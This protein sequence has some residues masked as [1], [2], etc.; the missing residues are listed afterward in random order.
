VNG[1]KNFRVVFIRK[2]GEEI[3]TKMVLGFIEI[4]TKRLSTLPHPKKQP[5]HVIGG[6]EQVGQYL[7]P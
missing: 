7:L 1:V 3:S 2:Q 4:G 6:D 5:C